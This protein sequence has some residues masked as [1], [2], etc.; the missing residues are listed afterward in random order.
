MTLPLALYQS[1]VVAFFGC[2][3][4]ALV[5]CALVWVEFQTLQPHYAVRTVAHSPYR[6]LSPYSANPVVLSPSRAYLAQSRV[7]RAQRYHS[8]PTG[9]RARY[10]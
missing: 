3:A 4:L 8:V 9:R 6:S 5:L 10:I 2:G 1:V 7:A